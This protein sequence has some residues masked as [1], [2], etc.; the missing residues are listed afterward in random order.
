MD[1]A[2]AAAAAAL[3]AK[4]DLTLAYLTEALP[5]RQPGGL[6]PYLDGLR[7]AGVPDR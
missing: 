2:R 4:P 6:D 3:E 7:A 1:E 5:T